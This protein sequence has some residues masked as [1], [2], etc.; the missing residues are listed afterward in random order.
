ML[1]FASF[2]VAN[3]NSVG[4]SGKGLLI[5]AGSIDEEELELMSD[6]IN[7]GCRKI[8]LNEW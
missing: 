1:N 6:A 7:E 4:V 2:L 3:N 8:D 5:Y